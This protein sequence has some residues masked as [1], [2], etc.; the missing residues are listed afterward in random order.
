V[1]GFLAPVGDKGQFKV[2]V[3]FQLHSILENGADIISLH[4]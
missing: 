3:G 4:D 1:E 2:C